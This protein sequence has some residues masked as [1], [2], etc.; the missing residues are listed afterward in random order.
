MSIELT[1]QLALSAR[2]DTLLE[3]TTPADDSYTLQF[4]AALERAEWRDAIFAEFDKK[5]AAVGAIAA[6][7][8][9]AAAVKK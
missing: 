8:T 2:D 4:D 7:A 1:A 5:A 9:A 3:L 6:T